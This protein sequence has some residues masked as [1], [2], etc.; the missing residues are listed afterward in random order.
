MV[1]SQSVTC[2]ASATRSGLTGFSDT[3]SKTSGVVTAT[4]AVVDGVTC[5]VVHITAAVADVVICD[6]VEEDVEADTTMT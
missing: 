3:F 4:V 5:D 2:I 1:V 6:V